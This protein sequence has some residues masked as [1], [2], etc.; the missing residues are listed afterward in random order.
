MGEGRDGLSHCP[1]PKV[2]VRSEE[3]SLKLNVSKNNQ[4]TRSIPQDLQLAYSRIIG[5]LS[6]PLTN[7]SLELDLAKQ[8]IETYKKHEAVGIEGSYEELSQHVVT[9]QGYIQYKDELIEE[10]PFLTGCAA[11]DIK[12]VPITS[13]Q[14]LAALDQHP[15]SGAYERYL[16]DSIVYSA[17]IAD[18]KDN[19]EELENLVQEAMTAALQHLHSISE[20]S[21]S[22]SLG[23]LSTPKKEASSDPQNLILILSLI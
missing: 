22:P 21:I 17:C 4:Q 20:Y 16:F 7:S 6:D 15:L 14:I 3:E 8:L 1:L 19:P 13:N 2:L 23:I 12:V 5:I 18:S 10:P 9:L 11:Y